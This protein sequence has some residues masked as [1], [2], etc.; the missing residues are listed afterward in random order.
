L[1]VRALRLPL[2]FVG[3]ATSYQPRGARMSSTY[4]I[5]PGNLTTGGPELLHQLVAALRVG[6]QQAHI[7]YYPFNDAFEVPAPYR[8]YEISIARRGD[9]VAGDTVVLPEVYTSQANDFPENRV[10]LW[11]LSVDNFRLGL[12][13]ARIARYLPAVARPLARTAVRRLRFL[14]GIVRLAGRRGGTAMLASVDMHLHQSEFA[15]QFLEANGLGPTAPLGDYIN[16]EY[17]SVIN[18]PPQ[19]SRENLVTYNPLK[20]AEQT[21][22]ILAEL[23]VRSID[24]TPMPI[25]GYTRDQV[26]DLLSRA[27]LY[28][29]FGNHPGKDRIP[30]EAAAMGACVIVNRRGS[31]G[32]AIDV[33]LSDDYKVN[34]EELGFE[35]EAASKIS[36]V[37]SDFDRHQQR[38]SAYR[39]RIASEHKEF[40]EQ[41]LA[42]FA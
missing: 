29:D 33:P 22:A 21:A 25:R 30:R 32:N 6:G 36:A 18:N 11:W 37:L 41:A 26:R 20:G 38:F 40:T 10:F 27:K 13:S 35:A 34:D 3:G 5:C 39:A 4:V 17:L 2:S 9:I 42:L 23:K 1:A 8:K 16:D 15:R 24:A 19:V 12:G 28:I 7:V 31:A 14:Y